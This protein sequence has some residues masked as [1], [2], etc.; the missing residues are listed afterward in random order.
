MRHPEEHGALTR[1]TATNGPKQVG[2]GLRIG[3]HKVAI[4]GDNLKSEYLICMRP[5][6]DVIYEKPPPCMKPPY[7]PTVEDPGAS[8]VMLAFPMLA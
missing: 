7:A 2:I 4:G 1:T 5:Y 3:V 8:S 6:F